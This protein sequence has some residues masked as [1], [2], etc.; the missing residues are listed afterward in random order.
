[1]N[2]I[3][4]RVLARAAAVSLVLA[5]TSGVLLGSPAPAMAGP[6]RASRGH[7]ADDS[8]EPGPQVTTKRTVSLTPAQRA[9]FA[10]QAQHSQQR[11]PRVVGPVAA[12]GTPIGGTKNWLVLNENNDFAY[13]TYVLRAVGRHIEVWVQ[14]DLDFP[15]GDCRNDGVRNVVTDAQVQDLVTQ[16]DTNIYPK[17]SRT[18]SVAPNRD[19]THEHDVGFGGPLWQLLGGGDPNYYAGDG[20]KTVTLVGNQR[21]TN[22]YT[23]TAPGGQSY[24]AG[25]FSPLYNEAYDRNVMSIDSY[26][27]LHRTGANPPDDAATSSLCSS[28][29]PARPRFYEATFAHEY[30]HLLEY[31]QDDLEHTWLNEGLSDYAQTLVGYVDP[32]IPYGQRGNDDQIACFQGWAG[33]S[34]FPYCGADNSLTRW[35]DRGTPSL[36]ADYG[37]AYSFVVYLRDQF[38]TQ[39]ISYLHRDAR[40][41]GLASLQNYLDDDAP[42]LSTADVVHDWAAQMAL[43]R[44]VDNGAKGLS[45]DRKQ[46]FTSARLSSAIDWSWSGSHDSPGAPANGSDYVLA[47]HG[48]PVN[49]RTITSLS[50][51]GARTYRPDPLQWSIDDAAI[52]AGIG[53]DL[54]RAAV[55]SVDVPADNPTLTFATRYNIEQGWDFG[56][57]QVSTDHGRTYT[58]LSND[59][60]TATAANGADG[61]ILSQV[62]GFTGNAPDYRTESFDLSA[63]VGQRVLLSFRYLTD[64]GTNGTDPTAKPGWWVKD[65]HVGSALVTTGTTLSGARSATE[66]SPLPVAG[67]RVQAVGWKLNGSRV[68]YAPVR[69]SRRFTAS[70]GKHRLRLLL[71]GADRIGIIV[72]LDDP[73][74]TATKNAN[75]RLRINGATQ[76]GGSGNTNAALP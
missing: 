44:W 36:L 23:P 52:Y 24:I 54:D 60:T 26:D 34:T 68:R 5:L 22:Y 39:V 40:T 27:W 20:A 66:A 11:Q 59:D 53:N 45:A 18:F 69:L 42:G 9:A 63:Y 2:S 51:T 31:Y 57:V 12:T 47:R 73:T 25:F 21:D 70:L 48:R 14:Q 29:Q 50:F 61:R 17:E 67:W 43:D 64:A 41:Q 15:P 4:L 3:P 7:L 8:R 62:P 56:V 1:M 32:R 38:G 72:T 10:R 35:G 30:Q 28:A 76:P 6:A 75:Y 65:V 71:Q 74:E 33:T 49:A 58:S 13:A 46:R 16:F 37:A 19:G 55:Y